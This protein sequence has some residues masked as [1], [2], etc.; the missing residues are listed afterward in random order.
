M[1][2]SSLWCRSIPLPISES[3]L[4]P[5]RHTTTCLS[6]VL[7]WCCVW[8]IYLTQITHFDSQCPATQDGTTWNAMC[9]MLF[10]GPTLLC[11]MY[12]RSAICLTQD[13]GL[14]AQQLETKHPGM[15]PSKGVLCHSR[16]PHFRG[17]CTISQPSVLHRT[18]GCGP[19]I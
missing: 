1:S 16:G 17:L 7:C 15:F 13:T 19:P 4:V 10:Q 5:R 9:S 3:P 18:L 2:A 12:H 11:P 14:W 8:V 6:I